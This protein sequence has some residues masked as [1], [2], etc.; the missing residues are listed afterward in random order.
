MLRRLAILHFALC[1][2]H[3]AVPTAAS[4]QDLVGQP[5]VEVVVEEEGQRVID[6]AV[7]NLIQ[8]RVGQPLSMADVRQTFDHLDNLR[9]FEDIRPTA[10]AMA[11]GVRVRYVLVPLHPIDKIE[12]T[13]NV[14][15]SESELRRVV[16][17]RFGRSPN[18]ARLADA[19]TVLQAE[20][21]R[22]GDPAAR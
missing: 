17:D 15:L 3:C 16:T 22:R 5:V 9:R 20:Y 18:P 2:L 11:G 13:G 10:E 4:V 19:P 1:I 8:T 6:A 21:R 7:L 14:A 12:F